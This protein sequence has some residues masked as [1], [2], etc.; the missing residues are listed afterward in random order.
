M[1]YSDL[2]RGLQTYRVFV[3]WYVQPERPCT[4]SA[5]RDGV[6]E[7]GD[8][9]FGDVCVRTAAAAGASA[10]ATS[11]AIHECHQATSFIDMLG[12]CPL[13]APHKT[14]SSRVAEETTGETAASLTVQVSL[15]AG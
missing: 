2:F 8:E 11:T 5:P 12:L 15:H 13:V 7:D 14:C 9:L 1:T 6:R 3:L 10:T 4:L